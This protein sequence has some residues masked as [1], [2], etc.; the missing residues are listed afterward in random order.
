MVS[1]GLF[2]RGLKYSKLSSSSD[3]NSPLRLTRQAA[4]LNLANCPL[5]VGVELTISVVIKGCVVTAVSS[6]F[7]ELILLFAAVAGGF[8]S[9][10]G[11]SAK[12]S[13]VQQNK[14]PPSI[15]P[16]GEPPGTV[17]GTDRAS[18]ILTDMR[19][20]YRKAEVHLTVN[21]PAPN[22]FI[23]LIHSQ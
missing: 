6:S 19:L 5:A 4:G 22:R 8:I 9:G 21:S 20:L 13:V 14:K 1:I 7:S 12:Q 18:L 15:L 2:L 23:A 16:W 17:L 10:L 3:I 11:S